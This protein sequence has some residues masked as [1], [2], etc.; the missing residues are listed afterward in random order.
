[1]QNVI[2][3]AIVAGLLM[4]LLSGMA[5]VAQDA[6]ERKVDSLF[7][8]ASS[9]S[10]MFEDMRDPAMDSIAAIG[11]EAVPHLINKF[12]TRSARERWTVIW[13]LQRI[14]TPA[15]PYLVMALNR[16]EGLVVQRVCW[17]LG[18]VGD[19]SAVEP[20]V[21]VF[22]HPRWQVRDQAIGA[23]GKI[24]DPRAEAVVVQAFADSIGQVRKAASVAAGRLTLGGYED[25][26]VNMLGDDFYG[27]RMSAVNTLLKL[28]TGV[29]IQ[30]VTDS[31]RSEN[32]F[33]S[34]L[35]CHILGQ[36]ATGEALDTLLILTESKDPDLRAGSIQEPGGN[37]SLY[38]S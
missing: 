30:A 11:V 1:M 19:S 33:T 27:A 21:E 26:L 23:L 12:T 14:G 7:V 10:I 34:H 20:L 8:I 37:V 32:S 9:G 16:P 5:T 17:A 25:R 31:I 29:V 35:G 15:V 4:V 13:I 36:F 18:D 3:K 38:R 6:V 2:A 28:D 24:G 22:S